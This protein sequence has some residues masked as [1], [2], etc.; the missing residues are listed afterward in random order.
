MVW[1]SRGWFENLGGTDVGMLGVHVA[2]CDGFRVRLILVDMFCR[3]LGE[4]VEES[5]INGVSPSGDDG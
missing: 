2:H 4:R 1:C 5:S 3:E